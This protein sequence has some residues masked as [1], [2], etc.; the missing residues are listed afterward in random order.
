MIGPFGKG[1]LYCAENYE[2]FDFRANKIRTGAWR[3]FDG[4]SYERLLEHHALPELDRRM[5]QGF[6]FMQD[7][8]SI[9]KVKTPDKKELVI[10]R[11]FRGRNCSLLKWPAKSPDLNPIEKV[12][13]LIQKELDKILAR[14][15]PKN[16]KGLFALI[17][18]AYNRVPNETVLKVYH[19][20]LRTCLKVHEANGLNNFKE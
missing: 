7:N 6:Y 3:G 1:T 9:H 16:K 10:D 20:F 5:P 2:Y 14:Y 11:L 12:H 8:A 19:T 4:A 18:R 13:F 15:R 17:Q